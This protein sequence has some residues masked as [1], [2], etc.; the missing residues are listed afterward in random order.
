MKNVVQNWKNTRDYW[1][2]SNLKPKRV[3]ME[4]YLLRRGY[5]R[6]FLHG[7]LLEATMY[8]YCQTVRWAKH[9]FLEK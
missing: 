4:L 7:Y 1:N 9:V 3:E 2:I 6:E 5:H 8:T